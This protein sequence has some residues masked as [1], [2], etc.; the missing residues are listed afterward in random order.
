V[1]LAQE[2][3]ANCIAKAEAPNCHPIERWEALAAAATWMA[4]GETFA[5]LAEK[6]ARRAAE[7]D[8]GFR[9]GGGTGRRTR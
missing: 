3:A 8:R 7:A 6:A 5:E 2:A 4:K 1:R 9:E